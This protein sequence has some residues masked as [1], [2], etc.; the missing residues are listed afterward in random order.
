[1][2]IGD[3]H[4]RLLG[5]ALEAHRKD[6]DF[7]FALRMRDQGESGRLARGYWFTGTDSYLFMGLFKPNDPKNKTRTVGYC[8]GFDELGAVR[9]CYLDIV[10]KGI[11]EDSQ[12]KIYARMLA[13]LGPFKTIRID[14]YHR[15][16]LALD[17]VLSFQEFLSKDYPRLRNIIRAENA[18][19]DFLISPNDFKDMLDRIAPIRAGLK[20]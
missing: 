18:E 13:D 8:V 4:E 15:Y 20:L 3:W 7:R 9:S 10:F 1:M 2:S 17:P 14:T 11:R 19:R 6:P 16:Y 12:R 5:A